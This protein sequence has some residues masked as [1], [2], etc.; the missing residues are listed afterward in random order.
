MKKLPLFFF[1]IASHLGLGQSQNNF[2]K[3]AVMP[4]PTAASLGKYGDIPVSPFTGTVDIS[5][6]LYTLQQGPLKLPISLSYHSSGVKINESASWVG[7]G[8]SLNAGG[9]ITRTVQ[10]LPDDE[11]GH[12]YLY[13]TEVQSRDI[14]QIELLLADNEPDLFSY[15]V[16]GYSGKFTISKTGQ[17][18]QSKKSDVKVEA[19]GI[20]NNDLYFRITTPDGIRYLFQG[21][22]ELTKVWRNDFFLWQEYTSSWYLSSMSSY[23][24]Q[25]TISFS[26]TD[27]TYGVNSIPACSQSQTVYNYSGYPS[28][29]EWCG[30]LPPLNVSD[31]SGKRLSSISTSTTTVEF[32]A[33]TR[34]DMENGHILNNT[35][36]KLEQMEIWEGAF[37]KK[38]M[39]SYDYFADNP[40]LGPFH[41]QLKLTQIQERSCDGALTNP[42]Y[43]FTYE[44]PVVNGKQFL[45]NRRSKAMDHWGFY[46]GAHNNDGLSLFAGRSALDLTPVGGSITV[47]DFGADRESNETYMKYGALKKIK[48]PTGGETSFEFEA[49]R[50]NVIYPHPDLEIE[51]LV[52][53]ENCTSPYATG[54]CC[55][56]IEQEQIATFSQIQLDEAF[57]TVDLYDITYF[58]ETRYDPC[59]VQYSL[60]NIDYQLEVRRA[61]D[62]FFIGSFSTNMYG[63]NDP[64]SPYPKEHHPAIS[65]GDLEIFGQFQAGVAYIFKLIVTDGVGKFS[66]DHHKTQDPQKVV[67]GLRIKKIISTEGLQGGPP[68]ET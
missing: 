9:V 67:G 26:Y 34:E 56:T 14:Q 58:P 22:K 4:A 28:L 35:A 49:N 41:K 31:I 25:H 40:A 15:S 36:G 45:P 43:E 33:G 5:I 12:G 3:D 50:A 39:F 37:C 17:C 55:G 54:T 27:E 30:A 18:L 7:L 38:F 60:Y 1:L 20:S 51:N 29:N 11:G 10:G 63:S 66:I 8:W 48:F 62:N 52:N 24:Q 42:A 13:T 21:V 61:S 53:L 16:N 6:P 23:D 32:L 68:V 65:F 57:L 19:L 2:I 46:N 59:H 47:F 44:G 64:N